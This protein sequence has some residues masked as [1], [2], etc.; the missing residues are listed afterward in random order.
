MQTVNVATF[1]GPGSSPKIR[2]VPK[3]AV[4]DKAALIQIGCCGVCGTDLHILQGHWPKP[5][6]WP[7]T[8]GHELAGVI[9][10]KGAALETDFMASR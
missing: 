6:P 5:L 8:L 3:P 9:V 2:T 4:P 7:F 1:D 10:E